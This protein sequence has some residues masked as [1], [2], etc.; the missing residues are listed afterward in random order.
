MARA[1]GEAEAKDLY[2]NAMPGRSV[3][4]LDPTT[5]VR[6]SETVYAGPTGGSTLTLP[7]TTNA[8]GLAPFYL[9]SGK[10]VKG[11]VT[12]GSTD[13]DDIIP[14]VDPTA[15]GGGGG[16]GA[17]S[18]SAGGDLTGTY[19]NPTL[20]TVTVAK[21]GTGS[22][23]LTAGQ[24]LVGNGTSAVIQDAGLVWDNTAKQLIVGGIGGLAISGVTSGAAITITPPADLTTFDVKS[25]RT[26][27]SAGTIGNQNFAP[28]NLLMNYRATDVLSANVNNTPYH[29]I[30]S[31]INVGTAGIAA[32]GSLMAGA[33][34]VVINQSGHVANEFASMFAV[35][36]DDSTGGVPGHIWGE[37]MSIHGAVGL[38]GGELGGFTQFINNY[39]NGSPSQVNS[40][41]VGVATYPG[42]G[43][44]TNAAHTAA[45][46]YPVDAGVVVAGQST[47]AGV[48]FKEAF[49]AGGTSTNWNVPSLFNT[50]FHGRDFNTNGLLLDNPATG[51]LYGVR[52]TGAVY[53]NAHLQLDGDGINAVGRSDAFG[54][55]K[56]SSYAGRAARG[57]LAAPLRSKAGDVLMRYGGT[58]WIAADD[59]TTATGLT[60]AKAAM[61]VIAVQDLASGANGMKLVFSTTLFGSSTL[62]NRF[63]MDNDGAFYPMLT[64]QIATTA[65]SGF[66][67]LPSCAGTP[68]GVPSSIPT[69]CVEVIY[70][71]TN[72]KLWAYDG[73]AWKGVVLA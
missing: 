39:Y 53:A 21:G 17:P 61:D 2:G 24:L 43:G 48:G 65:T 28:I 72:H 63:T 41:G 46:T 42:S 58:G 36:R 20:A 10:Y 8:G 14:V 16:G 67:A 47:G 73:G 60:G 52:V 9:A 57:T 13:Y 66:Y 34:Q 44:G 37:D 12:I 6:I 45:T 30:Q 5:N 18:G 3:D 69:G 62:T 27:T 50:A 31:T 70:D 51:N 7:L 35:V 71:T 40:Y 29:G 59:V 11:R 49:L 15:A 33:F 4:L 23:A 55:G 56:F 32:M 54:S 68:T 19:P 25:T 64:G 1:F 38:Q 22:T 26:V